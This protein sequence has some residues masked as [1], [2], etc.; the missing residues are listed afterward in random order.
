MKEHVI[1]AYN[2]MI[3][4][5]LSFKSHGVEFNLECETDRLR[6]GFTFEVV[7]SNELL[8]GG[9]EAETK[10]SGV[11]AVRTRYTRAL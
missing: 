9:N 3:D 5:H 4:L 7:L 2:V 1:Y 8:M 11:L 6:H 10:K